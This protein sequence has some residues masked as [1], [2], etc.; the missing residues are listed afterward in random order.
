MARP[1]PLP[2][3]SWWGVVVEFPT[4]YGHPPP[5]CGAG[6]GLGG[7][8]SSFALDFYCL[9]PWPPFWRLA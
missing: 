6:G 2:S 4:L 1:P 8:Y 5:L 3:G 7:G 9:P